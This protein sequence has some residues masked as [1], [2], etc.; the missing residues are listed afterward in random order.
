MIIGILSDTHDRVEAMA[1]AMAV[2]REGGAE[3]YIHCGDVGGRG[4]LDHL[5]GVPAAFVWGN[6]DWD[7]PDLERYAARL[8]IACH[9]SLAELDLGGKSIAVIHGDDLRLKQSLLASKKYDYLLHGHTH[10]RSDERIEMTRVINP[11]ALYRAREK[12]VAI[13]D[14]AADRLTFLRVGGVGTGG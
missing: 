12:T 9:G 13:L 11:G 1:A 5:A 8:G 7:R 4:V 10:V 6:N 3:F 14:T 2:L